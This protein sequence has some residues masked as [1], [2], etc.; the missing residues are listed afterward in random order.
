M[1]I[2]K[3]NRSEKSI[4]ELQGRWKGRKEGKKESIAELDGSP[5]PMKPTEGGH[6]QLVGW[7]ECHSADRTD[8][9]DPAV[10]MRRTL[11]RLGDEL[12]REQS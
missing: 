3:I 8:Y 7:H 12:V 4:C 9:D 11:S 2:N 10:G 1:E 6:D 5:S